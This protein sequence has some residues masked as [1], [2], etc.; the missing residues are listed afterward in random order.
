MCMYNAHNRLFL[1]L[2]SVI[3][4][5]WLLSSCLLSYG[6]NTV[7]LHL[8]LCLHF[9]KEKSQRVKGACWV[10]VPTNKQIVEKKNTKTFIKELSRDR[11]PLN[12]M[13]A[14]KR[15]FTCHIASLNR[16]GLY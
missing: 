5:M 4:G 13:E 10:N 1:L 14:N 11:S 9:R 15:V 2:H 8:T 16:I 6:P 12:A 3:V 7:A